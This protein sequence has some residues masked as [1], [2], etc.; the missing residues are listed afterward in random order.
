MSRPIT[1]GLALAALIA[2]P[3]VAHHGWSSFQD[4]TFVLDG[5]IEEVYF[6]NPHSTLEVSN[7]E[8][9]W[10]VDLAPPNRTARAGVNEDT[11]AVGDAVTATGNRHRDPAVLAMKA[12]AIEVRGQTFEVY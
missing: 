6:G 5:T 11:I 10:H 12:R 2:L 1:L 9:M 7:D 3:A 8:G 4:E